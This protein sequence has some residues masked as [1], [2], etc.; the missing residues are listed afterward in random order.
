MTVVAPM[1]NFQHEKAVV[2]GLYAALDRATP[3][4]IASVLARHTAA[5]WEWRCTWPFGKQRG[6]AAVAETFWAPLMRAFP[7]RQR[8]PDIFFAGRAEGATGGRWVVETG[9]LMG[10]FDTP[11]LSIQPTRRIAMLRYAEFNR[12]EDG[13]IAETTL[14]VDIPHLMWQAGQYPLPPQTG[15]HLV[16]PGPIGH[17]GL[18]YEPQDPARGEATMR[19][20][21]ALLGNAIPQHD[22]EEAS[23]LAR[24]WQDDMIWWGPGGIGASYTIE[25]YVEQ[26][27]RPFDDGLQHD[28]RAGDPLCVVAEGDFGGFFGWS[29]YHLRSTGGYLGMTA[30]AEAVAMPFIDIYRAEDGKL[31]ENWVFIDILG[32]LA[33]QGLDVLRRI[34]TTTTRRG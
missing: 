27:C 7:R 20:I 12:V 26:H 13:R 2:R 28:G 32:F 14:F 25:R 4:T 24:V 18:L 15:A 1:P 29:N 22:P 8:R 6:A 30:G 3:D 19:A 10:L 11:W 5:D 23:K 17:D 33:D 21:E 16:T 31:A 34:P 9:H